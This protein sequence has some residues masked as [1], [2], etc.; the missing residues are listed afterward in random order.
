MKFNDLRVAY[1][2]WAVILGLLVLML[3]SAIWTQVRS[4]A[5]T[6]V[7]EE[8]VAK[9]EDTITTAVRWRGLAE[10]AVTMSMGSLVTT[11]LDLK[12]DFDTRV[13]GLTARITPVQELI[14]K[15]A[16]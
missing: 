10:V 1:K 3:A 12:K 8:L 9:Y 15:T 11:D 16:T 2:L 14:T 5:A 7:T 13:A 6:D 4:R